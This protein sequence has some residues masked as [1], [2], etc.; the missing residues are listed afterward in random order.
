MAQRV[1]IIGA[2]SDIGRAIAH[3]FAAAGHPLVL[4]ARRRDELE[5]D[6]EDLRLRHGVTVETALLDILDDAA[7][8]ALAA[9]LEP[10]P[11]IAVCVVGLL[12]D[13]AVSAG[14][15]AAAELVLR[16]NFNGPARLLALLANRFEERGSGTLVGISSVAGDRGRATNYVYGAA[17]A[18]FTAF[19]SGLRNRLAA[20]GVHVVT[21]KPGF[22]DTRMTAGMDLPK[23][24]TA[25]PAE[26]AAAVR[27]ACTRRSD[28]IYVRPVWR[29]V[30]AIIR[31]IPEAVFKRMRI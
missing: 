18:G 3:D 7:V 1:L 28:V 5:R 12:G 14:D 16:S 27:R 22:V 13:Q 4:T 26:V 6:A 8:D 15:P 20:K 21:V 11:D 17:K 2:G 31:A 10:L 19:L 23:R 25:Q 9:G 30:M 29:L 24:L